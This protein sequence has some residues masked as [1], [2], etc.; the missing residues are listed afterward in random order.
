M[1]IE[2]IAVSIGLFLI[3]VLV[4]AFA[5]TRMARVADQLTDATGLGEAVVGVLCLSGSTSFQMLV[6]LGVVD[7]Y[8]STTRGF[9]HK[10]KRAEIYSSFP[11]SLVSTW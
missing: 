11:R 5:G 9:Y 6:S 3:T 8:I 2:S 4:I 1:Q 7:S 10:Y